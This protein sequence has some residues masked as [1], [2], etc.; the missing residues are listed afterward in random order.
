MIQINQLWRSL[1]SALIPRQKPLSQSFAKRGYHLLSTSHLGAG[2]SAIVDTCIRDNDNQ[3]FAIKRLQNDSNKEKIERFKNEIKTMNN[4]SSIKGVMPII[5]FDLDGLWYIMPKADCMYESFKKWKESIDYY[6]NQL[7]GENHLERVVKWFI[8]FSESLSQIHSLGYVH[9]DIKPRNLYL[10]NGIPT[11]GDFGIVDIPDSKLTKKGDKIGAWNTI[12]PEVMRDPK[13]ASFPADVYS[14]AKTMWMVLSLNDDGFDGQY[15]SKNPS[16]SLHDI[17]YFRYEYLLDIDE[18]LSDSTENDPSQRPT[19]QEFNNRLTEW[20]RTNND[21]HKRNLKEWTFIYSCCFD[22][23]QPEVAVFSRNEDISRVLNYIGRYARLN[24]CMLP[25]NGGLT[26]LGADIAAEPGCI[27]LDLGTPFICKP[28][29]LTFR[30]FSGDDAWNYLFL[31]CEKIDP[32]FKEG[33]DEYLVE[34]VP[35]HYVSADDAIYGVYNYD[36]GEKLPDGYRIVTRMNYGNLLIVSKAGAYNQTLPDDGRQSHFSDESHF[37]L[38]HSTLRDS[39]HRTGKIIDTISSFFPQVSYDFEDITLDDK[40]HTL[41]NDNYGLIS[42]DTKEIHTI[43]ADQH[44]ADYCFYL[45]NSN[46][47]SPFDYLKIKR[48]LCKDGKIREYDSYENEE[49]LYVQGK[50]QAIHFYN[51]I[52]KTLEVFVSSFGKERSSIDSSVD[53]LIR[54][55]RIPTELF[56]YKMVRNA[57]KTADDRL[58]TII[59]IDE[60]GKPCVLSGESIQ[61]AK[62]YPV[63][64][65]L[66]GA[67]HNYV[68]KYC[69]ESS[70]SDI[71]RF[72]LIKWEDYLKTGYGTSADRDS[73][74]TFDIK[75]KRNEIQTIISTKTKNT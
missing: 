45:T 8:A 15:E 10:Y 69:S 12:A 34:D 40:Y 74:D 58:D 24:Y 38:Y 27:M 36:T 9:R 51:S 19:M 44:Y 43:E 71:Y 16:M 2:G 60:F 17:P 25:V 37:Y 57:V 46:P 20:I 54:L 1:Q 4:C 3:E 6:G 75:E 32:I 47:I 64:H 30:S 29:K 28:R 50:E 52:N 14:L 73:D 18:L 35:G 26:L 48:F 49:I 63:H 13:N 7:F 5:D 21:F 55:V 62:F 66:I 59:A 31:E 41:I 61:M 72:L 67:R 56:T 33:P 22:N 70:I 68:G 53:V 11:I 42:I 65:P 23:T 39:F